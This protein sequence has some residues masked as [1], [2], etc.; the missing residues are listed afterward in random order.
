MDVW[1]LD[2]NLG[3]V[4]TR[5]LCFNSFVFHFFWLLLLNTLYFEEF[6]KVWLGNHL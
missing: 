4:R 6:H 1:K 5:N 2:L 3:S